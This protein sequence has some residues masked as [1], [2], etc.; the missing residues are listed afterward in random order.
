VTYAIQVLDSELGWVSVHIADDEAQ[1]RG[2]HV[3]ALSM[4]PAVPVRLVR[5]EV[6]EATPQPADPLAAHR[7]RPGGASAPARTG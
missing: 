4:R 1:A 5:V 7:G 6:P 2:L 3:R